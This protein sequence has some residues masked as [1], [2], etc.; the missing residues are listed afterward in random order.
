MLFLDSPLC[1]V[2]T[3][4]SFLTAERTDAQRGEVRESAR[5]ESQVS[6]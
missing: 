2:R 3:V 6:H 1:T 5:I 4:C